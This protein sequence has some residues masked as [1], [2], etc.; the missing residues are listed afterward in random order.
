MALNETYGLGQD[1]G[2]RY[3]RELKKITP[4][5]IREAARHYI[6]PDHYVMVVIGSD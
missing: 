1:Y 4:E 6:K 2:H 3:I 5:K